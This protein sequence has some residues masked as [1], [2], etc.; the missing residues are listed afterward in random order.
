MAS[1]LA[2]FAFVAVRIQG[3]LHVLLRQVR[4]ALDR[5]V[6]GVVA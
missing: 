2:A 3:V 4:P 5:L 6:V 1:A